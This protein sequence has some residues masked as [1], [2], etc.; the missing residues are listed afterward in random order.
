[1]A[2]RLKPEIYESLHALLSSMYKGDGTS[3]E[4]ATI[5]NIAGLKTQAINFDTDGIGQWDRIL[6]RAEFEEKLIPLL[7]FVLSKVRNNQ[8]LIDITA[9]V[10]SG[11]AF[12]ENVSLPAEFKEQIKQSGKA[13]LFICYQPE[14]EEYK[15]EI[16]DYL[17]IYL[18]QPELI[19]HEIFDMQ[20]DVKVTND[21]MEVLK[22][23]LLSSDLL[24]LLLSKD[25]LIRDKGI[26]YDPLTLMAKEA[27]KKIAPIIVKTAPVERF[28]YIANLQ[29]LPRDY[30]PLSL[31]QNRETVVNDIAEELFE[32]I[33]RI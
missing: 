10:K 15:T 8:S 33:Q 27:G 5:A 9:K 4:P 3:T 16:L 22:R 20:K 32:V 23:E 6:S 29:M 17:T 24:I 2:T 7:E 21:K 19:E 1:M 31:Q 18:T 28:R 25:F 11:E 12:V 13:K 30:V 14:V 26:C